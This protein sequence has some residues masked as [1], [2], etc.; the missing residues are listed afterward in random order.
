VAAVDPASAELQQAAVAIASARG[1]DERHAAIHA[2]M[3]AVT[4]HA[5]KTLPPAASVTM[6][7]DPLAGRLADARKPSQ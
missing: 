2:A 5:L 1:V 3:Q 7:A 6:P 4:A